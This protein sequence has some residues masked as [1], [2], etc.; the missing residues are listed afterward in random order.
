MLLTWIFVDA[1]CQP[2]RRL[3]SVSPESRLEPQHS[4]LDLR[5]KLVYRRIEYLITLRRNYYL[6]VKSQHLG[7]EWEQQSSYLA[8][9]S[10]TN[11]T[12]Q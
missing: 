10:N 5:N 11:R 1:I 12:Q 8:D 4:D 9:I 6:G 7:K 3:C 2:I